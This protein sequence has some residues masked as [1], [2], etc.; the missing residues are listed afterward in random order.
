MDNYICPA[1]AETGPSSR[2]GEACLS[3]DGVFLDRRSQ[4]DGTLNRQECLSLGSHANEVG[5][6]DK[7]W[8][9]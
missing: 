8:S 1:P 2:A 3:G 7:K 9:D 4:K 5:G 6:K